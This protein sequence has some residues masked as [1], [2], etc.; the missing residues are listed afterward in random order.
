MAKKSYEDLLQEKIFQPLHMTSST[1]ERNKLKNKLVLGLTPSGEIA[2]N[3]DFEALAGTGAILSNVVDL[4]KF[5]QSNLD[6]TNQ[7]FKFQ[8]KPTFTINETVDV[9]LAWFIL[10]NKENI[11][12]HNGKTA[13]YTSSLVLD[14][15]NKKGWVVL[16]NVSAFHPKS[17]LIDELSFRLIEE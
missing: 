4:A 2:P 3:W 5:I 8:Q 6:S 1:T 7:I 11:H 10:K 12:W 9:A 15:E 17:N 16:S 14:V 13:G